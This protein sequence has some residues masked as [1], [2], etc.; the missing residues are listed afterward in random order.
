[1]REQTTQLSGTHSET[2]MDRYQRQG[3][4]YN[5]AVIYG[6]LGKKD[7]LSLAGERF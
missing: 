4:A 6:A 7:E 5:I 1:M 3:S 2:R